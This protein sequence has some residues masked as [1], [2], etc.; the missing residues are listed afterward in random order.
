MT[1]TIAEVEELRAVYV[2]DGTSLVVA[3]CDFWLAMTE[4]APSDAE[5]WTKLAAQRSTPVPSCEHEWVCGQNE[6]VKGDIWVC[7]KC[8]TFALGEKP[9]GAQSTPAG[10][11]ESATIHAPN[12]EA[13]SPDP[14]GDPVTYIDSTRTAS[15]ATFGE[16]DLSAE[17]AE[18]C[19]RLRKL[20]YRAANEAAARIEALSAEKDVLMR[21][22]TF[23]ARQFEAAAN[24]LEQAEARAEALLRAAARVQATVP[25]SQAW[26]E[27]TDVLNAV[28]LAAEQ[29]KK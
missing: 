29:E 21:S 7:M 24:A 2:D 28:L 5:A 20:E 23:A 10:S 27:V 8:K 19:V 12:L 13:G 14:A 22:H 6:K 11:L 17:D 16:A 9:S 1:P 18:L 15:T 25:Y 26:R 3:L 4:G